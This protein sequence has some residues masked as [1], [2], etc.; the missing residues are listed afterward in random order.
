[1]TTP[2]TKFSGWRKSSL[3]GGQSDCVEVGFADSSIGVRD[4]KDPSGPHLEFEATA[5]AAFITAIKN[6]QFD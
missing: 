3:S 4:S 6:N 2:D 5:W 1:M